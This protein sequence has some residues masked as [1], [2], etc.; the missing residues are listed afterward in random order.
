MSF[1]QQSTPFQN[2]HQMVVDIWLQEAGVSWKRVRV[3]EM[4]SDPVHCMP[5][6]SLQ[7]HI[8]TNILMTSPK[9][10][11]RFLCRKEPVIA[12]QLNT[13][14]DAC[15]QRAHPAPADTTCKHVNMC[16]PSAPHTGGNSGSYGTLHLPF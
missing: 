10:C 1:L 4:R 12:S 14:I 9:E 6:D 8:P 3:H 13:T 2:S 7:G 11:T 16:L 15:H 5:T